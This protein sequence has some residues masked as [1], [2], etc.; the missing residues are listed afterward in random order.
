V[1]V[2]RI[3]SPCEWLDKLAQNKLN[4]EDLCITFDDA[5]LCQF[6]IALPVL[7]RYGLKAFWFVYSSVIEGHLEKMEIY[8]FFRWSFFPNIDDFYALFFRRV[9][10]SEF[11]KIAEA[12][13]DES[14]IKMISHPFLFTLSMT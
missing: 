8:R 11:S 2:D 9:L 1:G 12:V 14:E 7:E 3:L 4:G 6:E 10:I 5:L 13:L